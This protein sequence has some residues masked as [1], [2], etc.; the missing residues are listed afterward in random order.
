MITVVV[1]PALPACLAIA[2][3]ISMQRLEAQH[4]HVSDPHRVTVAGR[5]DT[6]AFDKTGTLTEDGCGVCC[7]VLGMAL[8][9][10]VGLCPGAPR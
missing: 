8:R 10:T 9:N 1:P 6:V 7:V 4:V 2:L 3:G 5:V